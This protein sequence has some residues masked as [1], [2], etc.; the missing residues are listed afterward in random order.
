MENLHVKFCLFFGIYLTCPNEALSAP[1]FSIFA[2]VGETVSLQL[3]LTELKWHTN[4]VVYSVLAWKNARH[5]IAKLNNGCNYSECYNDL[6]F[7]GSVQCT[8]F[9]ISVEETNIVSIKM[10]LVIKAMASDYIYYPL[11]SVVNHSTSFVQ[12]SVHLKDTQNPTS[13]ASYVTP[14]SSIPTPTELPTGANKKTKDPA[15]N[16]GLQS[17]ISSSLIL[18]AF[19]TYFMVA[20]SPS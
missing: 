7:L 13:A 9:N 20:L 16:Q 8:D 15:K 2:E 14:I 18:V 17:G 1:N 19:S 3:N 10:R 6:S 5:P 11:Y 4:D 12:I